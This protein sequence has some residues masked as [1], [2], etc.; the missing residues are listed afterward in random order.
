MYVREQPTAQLA[1]N[2][3]IKI[4]AIL[5]IAT[6]IALYSLSTL[7]APQ[8]VE[9]DNMNSLKGHVDDVEENLM[10]ARMVNEKPVILYVLPK[11][12]EEYSFGSK[13]L[14]NQ[15]AINFSQQIES[16]LKVKVKSIAVS[17]SKISVII[18]SESAARVKEIENLL[19][20]LDVVE[21][22]EKRM[23]YGLL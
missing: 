14:A 11:F 18:P 1:S 3:K 10:N 6:A 19:K 9:E 5:L 17:P 21:Y 22:V 8:Q 7:M 13:L 4:L 15:Y 20:G 2:N 12:P 23:E 16:K